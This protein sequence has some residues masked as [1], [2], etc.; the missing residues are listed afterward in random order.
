VVPWTEHVARD[1]FRFASDVKLHR[2]TS[3]DL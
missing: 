3:F 2:Y 1:L